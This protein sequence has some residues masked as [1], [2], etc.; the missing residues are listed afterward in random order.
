M[1][2]AYQRS[3]ENTSNSLLQGSIKFLVSIAI[4]VIAGPVSGFLL[5]NYVK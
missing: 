5:F 1:V 3:A 2:Q 4:A